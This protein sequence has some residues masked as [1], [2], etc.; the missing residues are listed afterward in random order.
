MEEL[1]SRVERG[2][3]EAA[4]IEARA[5]SVEAGTLQTELHGT[6]VMKRAF[7]PRADDNNSIKAALLGW[8]KYDLA[9]G[10]VKDLKLATQEAT[11]GGDT[12]EPF[13]AVLFSTP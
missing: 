10:R 4:S 6:L 2:R 11:Y 5:I 1:D 8:V 7:Y 3:I 12:P 13:S 9:H